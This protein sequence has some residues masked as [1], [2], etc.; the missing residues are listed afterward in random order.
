[1]ADDGTP[2]WDA[3][4]E[5]HAPRVLRVALRIVGSLDDA[6][7][8]SQDVFAE[9]FRLHGKGPVQ[10]WAG[11]LVRLATLR[12]IDRVRRK[13]SNIELREDDLRSTIEP[14]DELAAAELAQ[15]LRGAIAALPDQQ[16]AVFVMVHAEQMSRG[17][18]AAALRIS[19]DA[20]SAALYKA[21][22]RLAAQLAVFNRGA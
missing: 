10:S 7:D 22:E 14:A 4:V 21:R 16:A 18:V 6:E 3:I 20:V 19:P 2:D 15:W 17:E 13:R 9:A 5:L 12:A 11:L 8:V 1:M